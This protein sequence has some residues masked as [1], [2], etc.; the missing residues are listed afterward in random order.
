MNYFRYIL[1]LLTATLFCKQLAAYPILHLFNFQS[2]GQSVSMAYVYEKPLGNSKGTVLLLHGKN[3]S[4]YYWEN[5]IRHLNQKGYTVIAPEQL[6]FGESSQ[7]AS[8]Q[9]TFQQLAKNTKQLLDSLDAGNLIV[10]GHSMGGMLAVRFALMYPNLCRQLILE[11]PIGLEDWK[12]RVP[13]C[14]VDEEYRRELKKTR[15]DLKDYMLKNYF[16]NEWKDDYDAL[17]DESSK[18]FARKDFQQYAKNM[19]LTTD[20]IFTQPVCYEFDQLKLPVCLII[21]QK[22]KTAIGKERVD[23][24][25]A[26]KLGN[27]AELGKRAA[28]QIPDCK[29]IPLE[30]MGH[31]PHVENFAVFIKALDNA[32]SN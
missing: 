13:Y 19:A 24:K 6:G 14:S 16:H 9:F 31:I 7:P 4:A 1:L 3:F 12:L 2:Q 23:D 15:Q 11:D 10:L 28:S 20:M 5:T 17:L 32:L 22:D 26:E 25:T 21:G 27:Y 30:G 29:L 8:Y 18:F